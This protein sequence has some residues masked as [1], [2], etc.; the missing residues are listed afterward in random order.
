MFDK[1]LLLLA[2]VKYL[3]LSSE[4]S[5]GSCLDTGLRRLTVFKIA[6][7]DFLPILFLGFFFNVFRFQLY[8]DG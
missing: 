2:V 4:I 8:L 7:I 3:P 6:V 5:Y 1:Y